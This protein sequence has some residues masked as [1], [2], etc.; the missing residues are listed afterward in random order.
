MT[1][2]GSQQVALAIDAAGLSC[3]VAV[4]LGERVLVQERID[5]T[6]GQAEALLPLVD[7]AMRQARQVPKALGLV[8]VTVGPG[9]FTGIRVGLAAATGIALA[10]GARLI[11]VTSFDAV[12]A[13]AFK[14]DCVEPPFR[15]IALESRREDLYVQF[16]D[17]HGEPL[18]KP[19]EIAPS[20]LG[21]AID[22]IIGRMPLLI[23][24]DAARR[25]G[26]AVA[27]RPETAVLEG[28]APD[29][30][31]AMQAGLRL[32]WLASPTNI[33]RPL[34]LRPPNV[35]LPDG[36]RKPNLPRT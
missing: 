34:Y 28:S 6:Y 23:A 31:G 29:A 19:A 21:D 24:G 25:A 15:L 9:S 36:S 14:S 33:P 16:F 22:A 7:R 12:V 2:K 30:A 32:L 18:C 17:R 8:V 1:R 5:T 3:S 11:G 4:C 26:A 35:T 10:T 20:A 27:R 13:R